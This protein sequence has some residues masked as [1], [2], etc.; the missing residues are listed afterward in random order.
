MSIN[1]LQK[2][3]NIIENQLLFYSNWFEL[4]SHNSSDLNVFDLYQYNDQ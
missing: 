1:L 3:I 2:P 4:I